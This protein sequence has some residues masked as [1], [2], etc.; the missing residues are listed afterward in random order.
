MDQQFTQNELVYLFNQ[1]PQQVL[2]GSKKFLLRIARKEFE[3][4]MELMGIMYMPVDYRHQY[5]FL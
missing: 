3:D 4:M 1:E 5:I 2:P